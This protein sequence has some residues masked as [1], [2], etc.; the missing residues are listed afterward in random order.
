MAGLPAPGRSASRLAFQ[1]R[2]SPPGPAPASAC[3]MSVSLI[4]IRLEL[5]EHSPVPA[6]FG[7]SAAGESRGLAAFPVAGSGSGGLPLRKYWPGKSPRLGL[8]PQED[9]E[10]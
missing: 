8:L 7:F 5:A 4:V 10:R 1:P 9:M 2:L 6:G 3:P